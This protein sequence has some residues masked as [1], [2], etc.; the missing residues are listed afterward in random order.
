M[1]NPHRSGAILKCARWSVALMLAKF[2]IFAASYARVSLTF[3][4]VIIR[5]VF[6]DSAA[7]ATPPAD[8]VQHR[9]KLKS[10]SAAQGKEHERSP[11][12]PG[13]QAESEGD[14]AGS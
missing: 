10:A 9:R 4:V 6:R 5:K 11:K 12:S 14:G 7:S 2:S 3:F 1:T 13:I 8:D